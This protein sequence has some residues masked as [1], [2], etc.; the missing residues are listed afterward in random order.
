MFRPGRANGCN[1]DHVEHFH[2]GSD[3]AVY[4]RAGDGTPDE[5]LCKLVREDHERAERQRLEKLIDEGFESGPSQP[6][7][8]EEW[9]DT[10]REAKQRLMDRKR[11]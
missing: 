9:D 8:R 11:P 3:E 7:T 2:L 6:L 1:H 4:R 10:W 5:Y